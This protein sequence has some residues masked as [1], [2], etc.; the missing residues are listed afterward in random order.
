M[1]SAAG[2]VEKSSTAPIEQRVRITCHE[3]SRDPFQV[4][5][6]PYRLPIVVA[7]ALSSAAGCGQKGPSRAPVVGTVRYQGQPV[8]GANV[9]FVPAERGARSATGITDT[10]GQYQLETLG[11]GK[12]AILGKHFVS[13]ALRAAPTPDPNE[14]NVP[15]MMRRGRPGKPLIPIKYFTPE[16]S[17]LSAEVADAPENRFDFDLTP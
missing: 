11:L 17:G 13:V 7:I 10:L 9:A 5:M 6:H 12:G 1:R 16:N 3:R 8:F 2:P 4:S 14:K 15:P